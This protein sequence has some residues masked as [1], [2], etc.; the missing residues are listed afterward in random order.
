MIKKLQHARGYQ[1]EMAKLL[2][3]LEKEFELEKREYS[4]D[5]EEFCFTV[6]GLEEN[7]AQGLYN[8]YLM[9]SKYNFRLLSVC[10]LIDIYYFRK[11]MRDI[12]DPIVNEIAD[13]IDQQI[14]Q[15]K[16]KGLDVKVGRPPK[17]KIAH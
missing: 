16:E 13:L 12:F 1:I 5:S 10:G 6:D 17:L 8:G 11:E 4:H 15:S 14:T 7:Q 2:D 9:I 3:D